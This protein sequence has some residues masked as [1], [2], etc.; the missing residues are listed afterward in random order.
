MAGIMQI[1]AFGSQDVYLMGNPQ[2]TFFKSVHRRHTNFAIESVDL[3]YDGTGDF[4]Q[5]ISCK[6]ERVGDLLTDLHVYAKL[7]APTTTN[8]NSNWVNSIG[9]ALLEQI[10]LEIGGHRIDR[11]YGLWLDIWNEL[12]DPSNREWKL[13]GK[14]SDPTAS[15]PNGLVSRQQNVTEYHIPLKFWFC[16]KPGLA[17]PLIALQHQDIVLKINIRSRAGCLLNQTNAI[18]DFGSD[19]ITDFKIYADYIYL[20]HDERRKFASMDHEYLIEQV[21]YDKVSATSGTNEIELTFNHPIKELIWVFQD[22][23]RNSQASTSDGAA[24]FDYNNPTATAAS[25]SLGAGKNDWFN[26][27]GTEA[28]GTLSLGIPGGSNVIEGDVFSTAALNFNGRNRF[29][30]RPPNYF[31]YFQPLKYHSN[32]PEK[33]VYV[34]SFSF[35]PEE[36]QPSGTCNFSR[37]DNTKL[38]LTSVPS[39]QSGQ[40]SLFAVNYNI[41]RI[42]SGMSGLAY[43]S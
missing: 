40:F 7:P 3:S 23:T 29:T 9:Y 32:I 16:G 22:S 38:N 17:L 42:S 13:V 26:Y 24:S 10:D 20:D 18:T 4:G 25:G 1:S 5:N 15:A 43:T 36:H 39:A 11:Q 14:K 27:N 8:A 19:S 34:Y 37:L 33:H 21:Q 12:T 6:I 28:N 2:I 31:R 35:K 30:P 41:L